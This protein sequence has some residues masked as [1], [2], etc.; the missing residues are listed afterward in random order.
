MSFLSSLSA[1]LVVSAL[2]CVLLLGVILLALRLD[3]RL[4]T[5]RDSSGELH[6]L[7]KGLNEATERAHQAVAQLSAAA[8]EHKGKL[9][10]SIVKARSL[11]DELTLMTQSADSLASRLAQSSSSPS[12]NQRSMQAVEPV[13]A[14]QPVKS[15]A[16]DADDDLTEMDK[17][18]AALKKIIAGV[19]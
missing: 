17:Q 13:S 4:R 14:A 8:R 15:A 16:L 9:E 1:D 10:G 5:V 11:S 7:I 18:A 19:R 2:L 6:S 3:H 12:L